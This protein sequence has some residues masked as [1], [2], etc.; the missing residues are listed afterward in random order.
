[1]PKCGKVRRRATRQNSQA[2][3]RTWPELGASFAR[4]NK[5]K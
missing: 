1:M 4:I 2:P 3:A 5:S